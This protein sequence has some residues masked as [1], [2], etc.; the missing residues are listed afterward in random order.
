MGLDTLAVVVMMEAVF[1]IKIRKTCKFEKAYASPIR[2][3]KS[4]TTLSITFCNRS[5]LQNDASFIL[6]TEVE[7]A[8]GSGVARCRRHLRS[9]IPYSG[10]SPF[11]NGVDLSFPYT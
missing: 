1:D 5:F 8:V 7:T 6:M 3:L 2:R 10:L 4:N 9:L 11:T